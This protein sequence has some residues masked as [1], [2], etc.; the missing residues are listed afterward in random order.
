M[1]LLCYFWRQ[2][3]Q[4]LEIKLPLLERSP[5]MLRTLTWSR[6][7]L[8]EFYKLGQL[9]QWSDYLWACRPVLGSWLGLGFSL[10]H[11]VQSPLLDGYRRLFVDA[12]REA[13]HTSPST[14]EINNA[15]SY[16][17]IP[18]IHPLRLCAQSHGDKFDIFALLE[19]YTACIGLFTDVSGQPIGPI[20]NTQAIQEEFF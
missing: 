13:N 11:L 12:K 17:I 8:C 5:Q 10:P 14:T 9:H 3:W 1:I 20:F 4:Y 16:N 15:S 18:P 2:L 6:L 7:F 19:C